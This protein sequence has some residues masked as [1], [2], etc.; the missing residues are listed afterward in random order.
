MKR[1]QFKSEL[2]LTP[3]SDTFQSL[4]MWSLAP[5]HGRAGH[6]QRASCQQATE[7]LCRDP[8]SLSWL[9]SLMAEANLRAFPTPLQQ[10]FCVDCSSCDPYAALEF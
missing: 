6:A 1:M 10:G 8:A 2:G 3:N 9:P 5:G 7:G 4:D